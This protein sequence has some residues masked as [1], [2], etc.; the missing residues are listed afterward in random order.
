MS[1]PVANDQDELIDFLDRAGKEVKP[2][3]PPSLFHNF[4]QGLGDATMQGFA[5]IGRGAAIIGGGAIAVGID[6]AA[7]GIRA[8]G[9]AISTLQQMASPFG[10]AASMPEREPIT[11]AR[12]WVFGAAERYT[13]A[14][15][16]YW[17]PNANNLGTAG[18]VVNGLVTGLV[19]LTIGPAGLVATTQAD[20]SI[21]VTRA[22]GTNAQAV[23][24]GAVMGAVTAAGVRM[25]NAFGTGLPIRIATGA[26]ANVALD[27]S[28]NVAAGAI[29]GD[30][31]ELQ[32]RFD[33]TGE[34]IAIS[35][36][37]GGA[38]G[39]LPDAPRG[40]TTV[41]RDGVLTV[42]NADHFNNRTAPGTPAN[43]LA[44]VQ[45]QQAVATALEQMRAGQPVN[46][47]G[48]VDPAGFRLR[49]ELDAYGQMLV[50]LES[51]GKADAKA[52]TSSATGLHQFTGRMKDG[53]AVGTWP[54]LVARVKPAWA[55][56]LTPQQILDA[57]TD[58]AKSAEMELA[59]RRENAAALTR[60][61][62]DAT[63]PFNL[64]AAHHFGEAGGI[65]FARAADNTPMS[66]LL[67]EGQ[68]NA[69]PY[70]RGKTKAEA[71]ANWTE[72]ARQAGVDMQEVPRMSGAE[73]GQ[74]IDDR[75]AALDSL[76]AGRLPDGEAASLRAEADD[77]DS[78]LREHQQRQAE[79]VMSADPAAR[80]TADE[81]AFIDQRRLE[82]RQALERHRGAVEYGR[83]ADALRG[84]LDR[85][86]SDADLARLAADLRGDAPARASRAPKAVADA[87]PT[88]P[89][90]APAAAANDAQA[91]PRIEQPAT[92]APRT[93]LDEARQIVAASPEAQ[94]LSGYDAD[95]APIYRPM[96]EVLA[97][98]EA[99]RAAGERDA[100][101]FLA[102]A[103]CALRNGVV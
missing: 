81:L 18:Q 1:D 60:A 76:A 12:D 44:A 98:I 17:T 5:R 47:A 2:L 32:Q 15:V 50:A 77:L 92:A 34:S 7:E 45:H 22:G 82:I 38:F 57:R 87:V 64:Y 23:G 103:S 54:E 9:D 68:L 8:T 69:N 62:V 97:E 14:A 10:Q 55:E 31:P 46:V 21:D 56:G 78:L 88:A 85:I 102:A 83:Q 29:V 84:R 53:K 26:T 96:A 66:A 49:P 79:G 86:D 3:G 100:S 95:N 36:L 58:P 19:P 93:V 43:R 80:L 6:K 72:R 4:G 35:A 42:N 52:G 67:T 59:L 37:M 75:L 25:P 39:M 71:I 27:A 99:E 89:R 30:K 74:I 20:T 41:E 63:D 61:G 94:A 70:L 24:A 13:Q 11:T 65:K 16:D 33:V 73:V 101:A 51:G 40:A 91:A 48:Q 28:G 90:E